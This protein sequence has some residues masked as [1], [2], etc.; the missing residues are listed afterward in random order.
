LYGDD[1]ISYETP[2]SD[3]QANE[4]EYNEEFAAGETSTSI[5]TDSNASDNYKNDN[6][7]LPK[8]QNKLK[9]PATHNFTTGCFFYVAPNLKYDS[10]FKRS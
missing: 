8:P 1:D 4:D 3:E 6:K 7:F 5:D 2:S 9:K 10:S